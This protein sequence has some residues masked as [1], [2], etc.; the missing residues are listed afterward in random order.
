M[1]VIFAM[2][3]LLRMPRSNLMVALKPYLSLLGSLQSSKPK[4]RNFQ[5]SSYE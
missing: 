1:L 4:T 2:V 3:L 5:I